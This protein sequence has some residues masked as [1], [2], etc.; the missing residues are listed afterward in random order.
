VATPKYAERVA[1]LETKFGTFTEETFP[2]FQKNLDKTLD[3][4]STQITAI[5]PNGQTSRLINMSKELGDPEDVQIIASM[6]ESHKRWSWA[7]S[8]FKAVPAGVMQAIA[9]ITTG[10]VLSAAHGWIHATYPAIP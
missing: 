9:Y 1:V 7:G 6:V 10:I 4:I 5:S 3:D 2:T 8:P